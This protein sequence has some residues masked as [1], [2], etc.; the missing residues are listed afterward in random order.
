MIFYIIIGIGLYITFIGLN[1]LAKSLEKG[2][3]EASKAI[4]EKEESKFDS[5][6]WS[7]SNK[8]ADKFKFMF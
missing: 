8:D 2:L 1:G 7:P 4:N 3:H 5:G 6:F